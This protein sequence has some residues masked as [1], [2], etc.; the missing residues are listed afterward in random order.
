MGRLAVPDGGGA[1]GV[2]A[3]R[4][5][6]ALCCVAVSLSM[7]S[8]LP[9]GP[10]PSLVG[11][12][13]GRP[14]DGPWG[15]TGSAVASASQQASA[16][17]K[18]SKREPTQGPSRLVTAEPSDHAVPRVGSSQHGGIRA[19]L[20]AHHHP[21]RDER[22]PSKSIRPA[23]GARKPGCRQ[24][25][26][27]DCLRRARLALS[28]VSG[29]RSWL[30]SAVRATWCVSNCES[31]APRPT[32]P[33]LF[34]PRMFKLPGT[35]GPVTSQSVGPAS[36]PERPPEPNTLCSVLSLAH[37]LPVCS[38][39]ISALVVSWAFGG[40]KISPAVV[41]PLEQVCAVVQTETWDAGSRSGL[42]CSGWR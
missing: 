42:S 23:W 16:T 32:E 31:E 22:I 24:I 34:Q 7:L 25:W 33:A 38:T 1:P 11:G 8:M 9:C 27:A 20:R 39:S 30:A 28:V 14:W 18:E 40:R 13:P 12:A 26:P 4:P 6:P 17:R 19:H 15:R 41:Q 36:I 5:W 10:S 3:P 2:P 37:L 29:R 35:S 21:K